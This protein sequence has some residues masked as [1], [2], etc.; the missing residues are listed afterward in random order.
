MFDQLG[1]EYSESLI[2]CRRVTAEDRKSWNWR[3][4]TDMD[5]ME[6]QANA[7]AS[8]LLMPAP[9]VKIISDK[10]TGFNYWGMSH[11]KVVIAEMMRVFKVSHS[12]AAFRL[13]SLNL[14][15]NIIEV[16]ENGGLKYR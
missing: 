6:W 5:W 9:A 14:L 8:S 16:T 1:P 2:R 4:W 15:D 12:A 13:K 11:A 10:A 7:G 3:D